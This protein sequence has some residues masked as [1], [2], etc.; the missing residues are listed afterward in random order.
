MKNQVKV[1]MLILMQHDIEK[2]VDFYKNIGF[3]V[4]FHLKNN[5]A[6]FMVGSIKLGLCP[7]STE[8]FDRHSGIVLEVDDINLFQNELEKNGIQ[9]MVDPKVSVHGV[10]ASIKDPSGNILDI[11]QPTPEKVKEFI[12]KVSKDEKN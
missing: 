3:S 6:E 9:F 10:M 4:K 11:Y 5:W 7:T 1:G 2:A 8:P 12:E